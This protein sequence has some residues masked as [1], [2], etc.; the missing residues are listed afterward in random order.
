VRILRIDWPVQLIH[1]DHG[2]EIVEVRDDASREA[3][4]PARLAQ[5]RAELRANMRIERSRFDGD[6]ERPTAG[7]IRTAVVFR[8]TNECFIHDSR[9]IAARFPKEQRCVHF[10]PPCRGED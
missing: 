9:S 7:T 3:A 6:A 2:I 1:R 10:L 4:E 5:S 8:L